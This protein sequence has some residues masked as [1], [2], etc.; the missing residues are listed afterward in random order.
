MTSSEKEK[1]FSRLSKHFVT[2]EQAV[3]NFNYLITTNQSGVFL[4]IA[5]QF[6]HA[7]ITLKKL[8]LE[9]AH[10][11]EMCSLTSS[12][13]VILYWRVPGTNSYTPPEYLKTGKYDGRQ[14]TVWQMGILLVE[15]LSPIMAFDK[16][17][18]AIKVPP[19]IPDHLSPGMLQ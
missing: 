5:A 9:E 2:L 17:E 13:L 14:G 4:K 18:Q 15:I 3:R 1:P 16:P 11:R 8:L 19:R 6:D 7:K 10:V 12:S